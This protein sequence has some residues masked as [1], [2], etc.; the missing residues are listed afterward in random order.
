MFIVAQSKFKVLLYF[1]QMPINPKVKLADGKA[2]KEISFDSAQ[3]R[4]DEIFRRMTPQKK[5]KLASDFSMFIL[6]S[7]KLSRPYGF[8]KI[9]GRNSK[10]S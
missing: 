2:A 1:C 4:Q 8:S 5:L 10:N 3:D 9:S 6:S 7:K